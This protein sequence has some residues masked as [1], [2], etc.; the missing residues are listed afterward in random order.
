LRGHSA[1]ISRPPLTVTA[2]VSILAYP[3]E[4]PTCRR[5]ANP[6]KKVNIMGDRSPKSNQKKSTQKQA[7]ANSAEQKK[8][9]AVAAKQDAGKKR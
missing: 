4:K 8:Q 6:Q 2:P 3:S 7:R 5:Q 9:Q 1:M